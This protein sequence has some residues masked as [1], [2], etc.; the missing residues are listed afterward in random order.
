M[1]GA[2]RGY[3]ELSTYQAN[4]TSDD[5]TVGERQQNVN[6]WLELSH[7]LHLAISVPKVVKCLGFLLKNVKYRIRRGAASELSGE[8]IRDDVFPR[9]LGVLVQRSIKD[10][11][12][13]RRCRA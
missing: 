13:L 4:T 2:R 9:L 1:P 6:R 10:G 7:E 5:P 12:E 8:W 3:V 11:L